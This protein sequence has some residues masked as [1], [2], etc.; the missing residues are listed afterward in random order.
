MARLQQALSIPSQTWHS[1]NCAAT[2]LLSVSKDD[3]KA[4]APA[5]QPQNAAADPHCSSTQRRGILPLSWPTLRQ[6]TA[7]ADELCQHATG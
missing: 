1:S 4:S 7:Q 2:H 5:S 3:G 6:V